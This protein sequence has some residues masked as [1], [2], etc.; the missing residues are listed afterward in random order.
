MSAPAPTDPAVAPPPEKPSEL[1]PGNFPFPKPSGTDEQ[2]PAGAL[3]APQP[4]QPPP[5]YP[6]LPRGLTPFKPPTEE[7]RRTLRLAYALKQYFRSSVHHH[8][9]RDGELERR[10]REGDVARWGDGRAAA[11]SDGDADEDG[12]LGEDGD[13]DDDVRW[14]KRLAKVEEETWAN[15]D[16]SIVPREILEAALG[17]EGGVGGSKK[18]PS[19]GPVSPK[20]GRGA[21]RAR[22]SD[23]GRV[24]EGEDATTSARERD[25]LSRLERLAQLESRADN[26]GD[27]A[28]RTSERSAPRSSRERSTSKNPSRRSG[29]GEDDEDDEDDENRYDDDDDL[30]SDDD[31]ARTN[32]FDDDEG[33]D[34]DLGDDGDGEAFFI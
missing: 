26:E 30:D 19:D 4:A 18:R 14:L 16:E 33:L 9:E 32:G 13:E 3:I 1:L 24:D 22:A 21:K 29:G 17:A 23:G 12:D 15:V 6:P 31:Y 2:A 11:A 25:R 34:D 28:G 8:G 5:L 10:A 20:R 7:E 27:R